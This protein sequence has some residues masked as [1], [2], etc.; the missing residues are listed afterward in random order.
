MHLGGFN[1]SLFSWQK[2]KSFE[3]GLH[4]LSASI[5][6]SLTVLQD[7][8]EAS[9]HPYKERRSCLVSCSSFLWHFDS[10]EREEVAERSRPRN[11]VSDTTAL[12]PLST[13]RKEIPTLPRDRPPSPGSDS[14]AG[15]RS[16]EGREAVRSRCHQPRTVK[17][18][19]RPE[20]TPERYCH[21]S[22]H[23]GPFLPEGHPGP[24]GGG[25]SSA[26]LLPAPSFPRARA[27]ALRHLPALFGCWRWREEPSVS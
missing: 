20:A 14:W 8:V 11:E 27:D 19:G 26:C 5:P 10:R 6:R 23:L 12:E 13:S 17:T 15:P 7:V 21:R 4:S 25:S 16:A 2:K 22:A 24:A 3:R 1:I 18:Q 9:Q